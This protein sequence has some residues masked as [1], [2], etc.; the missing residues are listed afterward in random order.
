[1]EETL[2]F[3]KNTT[4]TP[5]CLSGR[6]PPHYDH[7]SQDGTPHVIRRYKLYRRYRYGGCSTLFPIAYNEH[8]VSD[9]LTANITLMHCLVQNAD[10]FITIREVTSEVN[11]IVKSNVYLF[12]L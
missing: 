6:G 3:G 8:D 2:Y 9:F 7:H 1:M 10:I 11:I 5:C 4:N 12:S